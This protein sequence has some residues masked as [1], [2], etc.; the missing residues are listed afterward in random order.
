ATARPTPGRSPGTGRGRN[1]RRQGRGCLRSGRSVRGVVIRSWTFYQAVM[2]PWQR[3]PVVALDVE[4]LATV[5]D[6]ANQDRLEGPVVIAGVVSRRLGMVVLGHVEQVEDRGGEA[7]DR[8]A[9][10]VGDVANHR[11][12]LQVDL[13]PHHST[14]EAEQ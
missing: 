6:G 9:F 7:R 11:Q 10:L 2:Q 4:A 12:R 1:R 3:R 14:A 13:P 5:A 8:A